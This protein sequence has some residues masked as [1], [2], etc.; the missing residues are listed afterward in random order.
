VRLSFRY[1]A[2]GELISIEDLQAVQVIGIDCCG[3][4]RPFWAIAEQFKNDGDA[5]KS[6]EAHWAGRRE[7]CQIEKLANLDKLPAATGFKVAC[8][9]VKVA[10]AST[11]CARVVAIFD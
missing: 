5:R 3:L 9:P 4:H 6:W 11:G 10:K 2:K 7:Y 1:K 8:F